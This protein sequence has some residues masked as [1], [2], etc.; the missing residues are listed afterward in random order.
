MK[1]CPGQF[2]ML[3]VAAAVDLHPVLPRP[4]ALYGYDRQRGDIQVVYRVMGEGTRRLAAW[5]PGEAMAT[6]GP[7]GNPFQLPASCRAVLVIGRG[8][9]VCSLTALAGEAANGGVD[10]L[11]VV[12]ARRPEVALGVE[13]LRRLRADPLVVTDSEGTSAVEQLEPRLEARLAHR[14]VDQ[15]YVCGSDRLLRLAARL[16]A[17]HGIGVQVSLEA[18]MACGLG[19]CHGCSSGHPGLAREAPLVCRDGPVFRCMQD[20]ADGD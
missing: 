10:V 3:T 15:I 4:M 18:R 13:L 14:P 17:R 6:V 7:L 16:G 19:Y 12:S 9:G 11:A 5:Q 8:I 20:E 2:A 1:A